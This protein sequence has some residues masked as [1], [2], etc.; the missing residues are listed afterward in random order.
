MLVMD[1]TPV[2]PTNSS[3]LIVD[4]LLAMAHNSI[5]SATWRNFYRLEDGQKTD[6]V[7]GGKLSCSWFVSTL[8]RSLELLTTVHLRTE[9]TVKDMESN[10]WFRIEDRRPGAV[11]V[12]ANQMRASGRS[13]PHIGFCINENEVIS[14]GDQNGSPEIHEWN[15]HK[16]EGTERILDG[17]Y[18][19][20][21]FSQ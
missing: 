9:S 16:G 14:T 6:A 20:P 2:K 4:T 13:R 18:W 5:G 15:I 11:I 21:S 17:I 19:H 12:Y 8:L 7:E 1:N 10:G 3:I